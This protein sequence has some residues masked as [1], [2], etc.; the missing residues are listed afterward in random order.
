V[1]FLIF[2]AGIAII[3]ILFG[4]LTGGYTLAHY[5]ITGMITPHLPTAVLTALLFIVGLRVLIFGLMAVC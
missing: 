4:T 2:F 3:M 5:L 1:R